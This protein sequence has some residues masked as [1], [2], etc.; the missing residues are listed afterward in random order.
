MVS[1]NLVPVG[2]SPH[3]RLTRRFRTARPLLNPC[4]V[5]GSPDLM[6]IEHGSTRPLHTERVPDGCTPPD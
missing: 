3:S 5:L 2:A 4:A 6:A 1:S